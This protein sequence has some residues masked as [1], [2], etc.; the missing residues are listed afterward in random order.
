MKITQKT[1]NIGF[2]KTLIVSIINNNI[3]DF[4]VAGLITFFVFNNQFLD[5]SLGS[6]R[7]IVWYEVKGLLIL[8]LDG[9]FYGTFQ[10]SWMF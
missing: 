5:S 1:I 9:D 3:N 4:K 6:L 2:R 8:C 7:E 10:Y